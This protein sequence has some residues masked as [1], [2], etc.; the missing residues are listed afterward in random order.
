MSKM[1]E[2][3]KRFADYYIETGNA[4]ESYRKAGYKSA[5][6]NAH[7]LLQNTAIAT[8]IDDQLKKKDAE[9]IASQDEVLKFLT[10][11]MRGQITEQVPIVME[12]TFEMVDKPPSIK[13]RTKAAELL[14]KRY[15]L[16]TDKVNLDSDMEVNINIK[17]TKD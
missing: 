5:R 8:Y 15:Q 12:K 7:K 11:V 2:K 17:G 10:T 6:G 13:D 14:G 4:E 9:R 3:Q 1:T 16:F